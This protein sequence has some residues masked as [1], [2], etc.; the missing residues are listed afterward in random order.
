MFLSRLRGLI[1]GRAASELGR[2]LAILFSQGLRALGPLATLPL[3]ARAVGVES[4]GTYALMMSVGQIAGLLLDAGLS[5]TAY[6]HAHAAETDPRRVLSGMT[7][8]KLLIAAVSAVPFIA[9]ET[10]TLAVTLQQAAAVLI[11]AVGLSLNSFWFLNLSKRSG[12]LVIS[13]ALPVVFGLLA[14]CCVHFAHWPMETVLAAIG[15]GNMAVPLTLLWRHDGSVSGSMSM[16]RQFWA[17]V[18]VRS[19]L[20][21]ALGRAIVSSYTAALVP[22]GRLLMGAVQIGRYA[23]CDRVGSIGSMTGLILAQVLAPQFAAAARGGEGKIREMSRRYAPVGAVV[24]ILYLVVLV[25]FAGRIVSILYGPSFSGLGLGAGIVIGSSA[26][27]CLNSVIWSGILLP[28]GM[29][30]G[31]L[32]VVSIG[33]VVSLLGVVTFHSL[34]FVGLSGSRLAGEAAIACSTA[35]LMMRS[36]MRAQNK[37]ISAVDD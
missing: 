7:L 3:V 34:G 19:Q 12:L 24:L 29:R 25:P 20:A 18:D 37:S 15:T 9:G 35:I 1:P 26:V 13:E 23:A 8:T 17:I 6:E 30:Q 21:V 28:I 36:R 10:L 32:T 27:G 33:A 11:F 5:S 4:F 31:F 14:A 22:A 16:A 2:I